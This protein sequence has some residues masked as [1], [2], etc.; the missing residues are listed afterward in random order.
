MSPKKVR[1]QRDLIARQRQIYYEEQIRKAESLI[2]KGVTSPLEIGIA[3]GRERKDVEKICRT[4]YERWKADPNQDIQDKKFLR[5][6]QLENVLQK[7]HAA[8]DRS[9]RDT[10]EFSTEER[11]CSNCNGRKQFKDD[12]TADGFVDCKTCNGVGRVII[13]KV[14]VTKKVGDP[15]FLALAKEVIKELA[16][17][18]GIVTDTKVTVKNTLVTQA[19]AVGGEVEQSV[20]ELYLEAPTETLLKAKLLL[21]ELDL[22]EKKKIQ[23][24]KSQPGVIVVDPG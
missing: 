8:F 5:S 19:L 14:K 12:K 22:A 4:I 1:Y 2:L 15:A 16:K 20:R 3:L 18:D 7:A 13:E 11:I 6:K 17:I 23:T 24:V 21:E 9:C 10:E